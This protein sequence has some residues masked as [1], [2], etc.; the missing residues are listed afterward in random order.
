M[1][2]IQNNSG[3]IH[4][5]GG[6]NSAVTS[7]KI[8]FNHVGQALLEMAE[9]LIAKADHNLVKRG[10]IAT[11]N[12]AKS[13]KVVNVQTNANKF[14]LD[15]EIASTY[16]FLDQGVNGVEKNRGS[17]YSFK[18]KFANKKMAL[19]ILKWVKNRRVVSKYKAYSALSDNLKGKNFG[20]TERKNKKIKAMSDA[21][22]SQKS[23]AY[24]ISVGIKKKGLKRTLFFTDAITAT[25]KEQKKRYA[26]ALKLDII[27]TINKN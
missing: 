23:L 19:A 7:D 4:W 16:K 9:F 22:T 3:T 27:E 8:E 18:T 25:K 15:I 2:G 11:G 24:A 6:V 13:M 10:N 20:A 5:L 17:K 1:P 21:A 26:D 12:T 14:S